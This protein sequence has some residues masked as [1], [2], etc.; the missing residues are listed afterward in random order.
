MSLRWRA[1]SGERGGQ[2]RTLGGAQGG[3]TVAELSDT[4]AE[5]NGTIG[6][7]GG[8]GACVRVHNGRLVHNGS[9]GAEIR[10]AASRLELSDTEVSGN[11]RVAVYAHSGATAACVRCKI[12][13]GG[14]CA[15]L[16]GGREG[17]DVRGGHVC[18]DSCDADARH[19][20]RHGGSIAVC[21][22]AAT[23]GGAHAAHSS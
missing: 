13:A 16:C 20:E 1:A 14:D 12:R 6:V 3:G 19:V 21:E 4:V 22:R 8:G 11:G 2:P 10:D 18:I 15:V 5:H 7:F 9:S 17:V 23:D